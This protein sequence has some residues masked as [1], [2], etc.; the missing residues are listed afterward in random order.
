MYLLFFCAYAGQVPFLIDE[1]R[2]LEVLDTAAQENEECI[3]QWIPT[4]MMDREEK[5]DAVSFMKRRGL[6]FLVP[7]GALDESFA[8]TGKPDEFKV[9]IRRKIDNV[10]Y[11]PNHILT[12][13]QQFLP[14]SNE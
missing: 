3:A 6:G 1:A 13:R 8:Y 7:N 11:D 12:A 4:D 2:L 5:E 10:F 14:E 9:W